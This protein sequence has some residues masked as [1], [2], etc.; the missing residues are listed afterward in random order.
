MAEPG[1]LSLLVSRSPLTWQL[2]AARAL[3]GFAQEGEV[4]HLSL[5]AGG[6]PVD[7]P[8]AGVEGGEQLGG[9][10]PA[11]LVLDLERSPRPRRTGRYAAESW[12]ERDH[13]VEAEHHLVLVQEA[14]QQVSHH[15][16]LRGAGSS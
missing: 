9:T 7:A 3:A 13:L 11:I 16:D 14:R 8:R 4:L 6:H 5:A 1:S 10:G 15:A 12:L 2:S